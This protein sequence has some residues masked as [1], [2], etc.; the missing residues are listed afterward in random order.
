M[1]WY[2]TGTE[3][4]Q[5][6]KDDDDKRQQ[7]FDAKRMRFWLPP[8]KSTKIAFLD[9]EGQNQTRPHIGVI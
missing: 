1:E 9:S 7:D 8:E 2:K 3:G 4:E 6:A 5:R